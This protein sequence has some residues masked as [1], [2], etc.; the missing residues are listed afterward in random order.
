MFAPGV[1]QLMEEFH[2]SS[3]TLA[4]FV[5]SIFVLGF[6]F[7]PLFLAPLSELYGRLIVYD[8]C[9]VLFL[10]FTIACAVASNLGMLIGFRFLAGLF[11]GVPLAI[12]GGTIAD[13]FPREQRGLATTVYSMGAVTGPAFG[14]VIGGYLSQAKDW[15]WIFW[16]LSI[17]VCDYAHLRMHAG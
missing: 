13:L 7:G 16:L 2:S 14:P 11:G 6:A 9:A 17:M 12:G 10:V 15:R 8:V 4:S 3:E 1:P 5:V